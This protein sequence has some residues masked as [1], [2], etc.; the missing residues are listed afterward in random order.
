M[1]E[2][3]ASGSLAIH[4][5]NTDT[6]SDASGMACRFDHMKS[7]WGF[8]RLLALE[9]FN[10]AGFLDDNDS[11][12][13]G[14]ELSVPRDTG[15]G[16]Y[17]SIIKG[18]K[19]NTF[20]WKIHNFSDMKDEKTWS[21]EFS[22][23]DYPWWLCLYPIGF[24]KAHGKSISLYLYLGAGADIPEGGKL[25]VEYKLRM[26]N[27]SGDRK[28]HCVKEDQHWFSPQTHSEGFEDF[29]ALNSLRDQGL[30]QNDSLIVEVEITF[31]AIVRGLN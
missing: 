31:M 25:Y 17:M 24:G 10:T 23:G 5:T 26:K 30:K 20:T 3:S 22:T 9:T 14:V 6:S 1:A 2:V 12:T 19:N 21:D 11:C 16:E 13:F 8:D 29:V 28:K 15:K 4:S 27:H 7:E 18:L